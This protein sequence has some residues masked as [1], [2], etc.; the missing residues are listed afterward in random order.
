ML[1]LWINP[2]Q[3]VGNPSLSVPVGIFSQGQS[4]S[5]PYNYANSPYSIGPNELPRSQ[6]NQLLSDKLPGINQ[7]CILSLPYISKWKEWAL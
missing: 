7:V 4:N 6:V 5:G 1:L 2:I 3:F